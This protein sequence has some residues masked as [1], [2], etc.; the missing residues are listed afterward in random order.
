MKQVTIISG[1]GGTGKTTL[2]AAFAALARNAVL[3]D[4]DVDAADL[5]LILKPVVKKTVGFHGLPVA[6]IDEEK[7]IKCMECV[8]HCQFE[9][10][11]ENVTVKYEACEGCG[12]CELVC[13]EDA[14]SMMQRDS[15]LLYE[16]E[17]RFGPMVHARLNTAEESSG[18]LVTE[19]RQHA[20][21]VAKQKEKD[22]VLID[23]PPGV[24]CPVISAITGVD[25]VVVVTEPTFSGIHDLQRVIDVANH[26]EIPQAVIINKKDINPK[27]TEEIE[28]FCKTH[29][30]P[31]LGSIP[32][33]TLVTKAM[34]EE[35]AIPEFDNGLVT[36]AVNK[37]WVALADLLSLS[38]DEP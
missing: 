27:K 14:V 28:L 7:C 34:I 22:V 5:H 31:L 33:D 29:Q 2:T 12:V 11:S 25:L 23:G 38:L 10:I 36:S 17:T 6:K 37:S 20:E 30:I 24:G 32:Y 8:S 21:S 3:A 35:K 9:A 16:S 19:V 13:P 18:K 26:F 1:K 4:C 15:G